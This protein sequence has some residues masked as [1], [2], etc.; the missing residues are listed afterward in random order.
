M[1]CMNLGRIEKDE[2]DFVAALR[3]VEEEVGFTANDLDIHRN[4]QMTVNSTMKNGKKKI[5]I[6]WPA[7]LKISN[8]DPTLSSEHCE[9]RW[10][11]KDEA[12]SLYGTESIPMF[13]QC[14]SEFQ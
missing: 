7:E 1:I 10:V 4:H 11:N 5:S 13:T 2:E 6:Y 9:Y 3:E 14:E 8:K 12:S